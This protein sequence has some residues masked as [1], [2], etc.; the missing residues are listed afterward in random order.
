MFVGRIER[1]GGGGGKAETNF[2][3]KGHA[4]TH[5]DE[6]EA[7]AN[8]QRQ[9]RQK[10]YILDGRGVSLYAHHQSMLYIFFLFI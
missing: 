5:A 3:Y 8:G 6:A 1:G 10:T 4:R 9:T 2:V 7:G